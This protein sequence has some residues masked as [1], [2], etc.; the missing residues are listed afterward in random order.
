[1]LGHSKSYVILTAKGSH[2]FKHWETTYPYI[3]TC[4]DFSLPHSPLRVKQADMSLV[5]V[6]LKKSV[7]MNIMEL[8]CT[9]ALE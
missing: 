1:M 7:D 9:Y 5:S 4:C 3:R 2:I 6:P 8:G